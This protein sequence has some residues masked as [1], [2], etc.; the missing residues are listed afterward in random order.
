MFTRNSFILPYWLAYLPVDFSL[1]VICPLHSSLS[2][3]SLPSRR[4]ALRADKCS[5]TNGDQL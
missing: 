1:T 5:R 2:F 4:T 3:R